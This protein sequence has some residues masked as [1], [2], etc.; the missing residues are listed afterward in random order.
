MSDFVW[1]FVMYNVCSINV[2]TK[3]ED[4]IHWHSN[5]GNLVSIITETKLR[6]SS[7]P[8][9]RNKFDGVRVFTSGLD[10]GFLGAG[11]AIIMNNFLAH[12][13]CKISEVSN[14]LLS[15][16]LLFKNKLFVLILGLYTGA[17]LAVCFSQANNVNSM[18]AKACLNL[19]LV[20]SLGGSFYVKTLT[21]TNS[22]SMAK[23]INFLFIF[24][25]LVNA[26]VDCIVSNVGEF[27][28]TDH[29]AVFVS[30]GLGGLLDVQLNFLHKQANK[31]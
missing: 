15:V 17:S 4:V 23:T 18:I 22:Q 5:S 7:R 16:K 2:P 1:K 12:H 29:W 3:Q 13:V 11:L 24:S 8:W 10:K 19:G 9:I 27:F 28:D 14:W 25:N 20:N 21:W 26:V 6:F 31:D 30:V